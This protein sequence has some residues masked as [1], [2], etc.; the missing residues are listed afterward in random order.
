MGTDTKTLS[1]PDLEAGVK[2]DGLAEGAAAARPRRRRGGDAGAAGRR[3]CS[4][5]ARP[6]PTT[7][8]RWPRGWWS[9]TPSAAPGTTP[10]SIC[11]PARRSGAPGAQPHRL[12]RGR[13]DATAWCGCAASGRR[14]A[15]APRPGR[16]PPSVGRDRRRGPG[17]RRLR[18]DPA[19]RGLRG[20][21]H[22]G[23]ATSRPGR[24]IGP[25]CRRTTWPGTRARGVDPAARA[26]VLRASRTSS[27]VAGRPG[28][29]ASTPPPARVT[30]ASG[31]HAELRRA[32][33]G[34][35][36]RAAPPV[37]P[38][39]RPAARARCCA[40]WPTAGRSS[41]RA[42]EA[43]RA[44]VIG[45]SFIGLEVAASLRAARPGGGRGRARGGAARA[46]AGRRGRRASSA[47]AHEQ[48]RA[49]A[50]TWASSAEPSTPARWC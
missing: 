28:R 50:S 7:A 37:D 8:A 1:G 3:R 41:P 27:F 4:P 19:P 31:T 26:R 25:T 36:R 13:A 47:Q 23:R 10:A 43:K 11:A 2:W 21:G 42:G 5:S 38:G 35:R 33:A 17:G 12:L 39:R 32:G 34:H 20:P 24:S 40:R 22:A 14:P 9:A 18:R 29:R 6:A 46:R 44:V 16:A 30:L 48:Q 45:A 15:P 49:C